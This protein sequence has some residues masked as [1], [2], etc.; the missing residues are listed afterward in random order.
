ME[1]SARVRIRVWFQALP[2]FSVANLVAASLWAFL[3]SSA[4]AQAVPGEHLNEVQPVRPD[5]VPAPPEGLFQLPPVAPA[6][7]G[8]PASDDT[9]RLSVQHIAFHGNTVISS[10]ELELLAA[11]YAGRTLTGAEIE[12]LRQSITKRYVNAGYVN[13]GAL[14]E[15]GAYQAGTLTYTIVEGRLSAIRLSGL[16]GLNRRYITSRLDDGAAALDIDALRDRF[17]LLLADPLIS[18]MNARL[19]PGSAL[20]EADLDIDVT[21]AAPYQLTTY[22]NNY[23]PPSIGAEAFGLRASARNLTGQGDL[24][25]VNEETPIQGGGNVGGGLHWHMPILQPDT[26]LFIQYDH[27]DSAVTEEPVNVLGIKSILV[28]KGIGIEQTLFDSLQQHVSIALS[29]IVRENR[30]SLLGQPFSFIPGEPNG[31]T[32]APEWRFTQDYSYRTATQVL[33]VRST[34]SFVKDNDEQGTGL[35]P[36]IEPDRD[37]SIWLGQ[38]QYA[39]QVLDNGAQLVVR[40]AVQETSSHLLPLD[41]MTIGGDATVRGFRE[42]QLL[43]D[44]GQIINLEFNYP[45]MRDPRSGWDLA[46]IPFYDAGHGRS[47]GQPYV[48]LTSAGLAAQMHWHG[49]QL[50]VSKGYRLSYPNALVTGRGNLQDRGVYFQLLYTVATK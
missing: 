40:A 5:F 42:N 19:V 10:A 43:S 45:V 37:Y 18:Q 2:T 9:A 15:A 28:S 24:L 11:P 25:E 34:F 33:A 30:T 3:A 7:A 1:G 14:L 44:Q 49:L 39:R 16:E 13:S 36:S 26:Q 47:V 29:R 27:G 4:Q 31:D 22:F 41:A 6:P 48:T 46:L 20:G 35:P 8:D 32:E 12:A 23:R 38:A 21:R 50:D 17:Q